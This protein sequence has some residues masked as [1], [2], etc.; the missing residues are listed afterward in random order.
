[1]LT[2][3]GKYH[4]VTAEFRKET[5]TLSNKEVIAQLRSIGTREGSVVNN[6]FLKYEIDPMKI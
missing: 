6:Y 2:L 5:V 3:K 4:S 1:M